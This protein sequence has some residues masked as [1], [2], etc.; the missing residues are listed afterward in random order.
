M[1]L[2]NVAS[3]ILA[4]CPV[5]AL[6][7]DVSSPELSEAHARI[8]VVYLIALLLVVFLGVAARL[9]LDRKR[10][11]AIA[12]EPGRLLG[13]RTNWL[14]LVII[15]WMLATTLLIGP[16]KGRGL[17]KIGEICLV[18]AFGLAISDLS[19]AGGPHAMARLWWVLALGFTIAAVASVAVQLESPERYG[20]GGS[21]GFIHIRM[22]G[23]SL[24]AA[25][26]ILTGF[27]AHSRGLRRRYA[28][29]LAGLTVLWCVL[30]WTASRGGIATT[31]F[32]T[33]LCAMFF[34]QLREVLVPWVA[35]IVVGFLL[36][37]PIP[38]YF[39]TGTLTAI[40]HEMTVES[41]GA[42]RLNI[43][44]NV[45]TLIGQS[46]WTGHGYAQ[47]PAL[48][49][50]HNPDLVR[51]AHAH[52]IVLESLLAVGIPGT[53]ILAAA[54]IVVWFRW[55]FDVRKDNT[56]DR[57]AAFLVITV[58][59][60]YSFVDAVYYY[61]QSLLFFAVAVGILGSRQAQRPPK[62][63]D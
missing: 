30:F 11:A 39:S 37:L 56:V 34:V 21:A 48:M 23:F 36:S 43:W 35:A 63:I 24:A 29:C 8:Y 6:L 58:L 10:L 62:E 25:I 5:L 32:A 52:N 61:P 15:T 31:I 51:V 22:F 19:K 3:V 9:S 46:P 17:F 12:S 2:V 1:L 38:G 14:F 7:L 55:I 53:L 42:G 57:L 59:Y 26:A 41:L 4:L 47:F 13:V 40:D 49:E 18:V 27:L 20:S 50:V 44:S 54:A 60:G 28:V 16:E 45:L 33:L